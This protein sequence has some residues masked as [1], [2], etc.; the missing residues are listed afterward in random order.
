LCEIEIK[1][2]FRL[3][4]IEIPVRDV[5]IDSRVT[6]S[7]ETVI[8]KL[9][10]AGRGYYDMGR[11]TS[12]RLAVG[13]GYLARKWFYKVGDRE[14][15]AHL[16]IPPELLFIAKM[17]LE[18]KFTPEYTIPVI[19]FV[20]QFIDGVWIDAGIEPGGFPNWPWFLFGSADLILGDQV[21]LEG[22]VYFAGTCP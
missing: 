18:S 13:I 17:I 4:D 14:I 9:S 15:K 11:L 7:N 1:Y 16:V 21:N 8:Q 5:P 20:S 22:M 10:E 2:I 3:D 12:L 6:Y 19:N